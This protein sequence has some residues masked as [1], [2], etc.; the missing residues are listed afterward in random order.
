[1][2]QDIIPDS[3]MDSNGGFPLGV[4][5]PYLVT[6]VY[7]PQLLPLVLLTSFSI[8]VIVE[9]FKINRKRVKSQK[10]LVKQRGAAGVKKRKWYT[11][12]LVYMEK[13]R[14]IK[15]SVIMLLTTIGFLI[16]YGLWIFFMLLHLAMF[17]KL[18]EISLLYSEDEESNLYSKLF[19]IH[20]MV[21]FAHAAIEPM[22]LYIILVKPKSAKNCVV[23]GATNHSGLIRCVKQTCNGA[24][25]T[26]SANGRSHKVVK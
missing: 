24:T 3:L 21:G 7:I 14:E 5:T 20:E 6:L 11:A 4:I 19:L 2:I 25:T 13:N 23:S 18:V 22:I 8:A 9:L 26:P 15:L 1:M 12:V 17:M 16:C 10:V